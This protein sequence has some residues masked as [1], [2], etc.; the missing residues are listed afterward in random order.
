[1][2]TSAVVRIID[3]EKIREQKEQE[4]LDKL[5]SH[6]VEDP[7]W[8]WAPVY[9]QQHEH[10]MLPW[11]VAWLNQAIEKSKLGGL[12][13]E[14]ARQ[15]LWEE[16]AKCNAPTKPPIAPAGVQIVVRTN[17]TGLSGGSSSTRRRIGHEARLT[18]PFHRAPGSGSGT[19]G[20]VACQPVPE[21]VF[22]KGFQLG[23]PLR[24]FDYLRVTSTDLDVKPS[25]TYPIIYIRPKA[26]IIGSFAWTVYFLDK[27]V[28]VEI[29]P[30]GW[31][32]KF[33]SGTIRAQVARFTFIK[34]SGWWQTN[35][36][37]ERGSVY[38]T[39][40]QENGS[41]T[42]EVEDDLAF[43]IDQ[44]EV[45]VY[46]L[47]AVIMLEADGLMRLTY[48][49]DVLLEGSF[50][51]HNL[52]TSSPTGDAN[53]EVGSIHI[54][55][56]ENIRLFVDGGLYGNGTQSSP[57]RIYR[58]ERLILEDLRLYND[59][60]VT[61][62][63]RL[64]ESGENIQLEQY[65]MKKANDITQG[66]A[67]FNLD[68]VELSY[69]D[70]YRVY[71]Y[72]IHFQPRPYQPYD[73]KNGLFFKD[74]ALDAR[75]AYVNVYDELGDINKIRIKVKDEYCSGGDG[76]EGNPFITKSYLQKQVVFEISNENTVGGVVNVTYKTY[77]TN[78]TYEYH[79]ISVMAGETVEVQYPLSYWS[80]M[81]TSVEFTIACSENTR[82]FFNVP[83]ISH[84]KKYFLRRPL[85]TR[86]EFLNEIAV[87]FK[88]GR[89]KYSYQEMSS[90]PDT[91]PCEYVSVVRNSW[92][93]AYL[94]VN[95]INVEVLSYSF[96]AI[97]NGT[98]RF[99]PSSSSFS[100][101]ETL[102]SLLKYCPALS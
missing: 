68:D 13:Y 51:R 78:G 77:E 76:T 36:L 56:L 67:L 63:F 41:F 90:D 73:G 15:A 54:A 25:L 100:V 2:K 34:V 42:M 29:T 52:V 96:N 22:I 26:T 72:R 92:A 30:G 94:G 20:G 16:M 33:L 60:P 83:G 31:S 11:S 43:W 46:A 81:S 9:L 69:E 32:I 4:L 71:K 57:Y 10:E 59:N 79:T 65:E 49:Q 85:P 86:E 55:A 74:H 48:G 89:I 87:T 50:S 101:V 14:Q 91:I 21:V 37:I 99:Y 70:I 66:E 98:R 6:D 80:S 44:A 27:P 47:D 17:P 102:N 5:N 58:K 24:H 23:V 93:D 1:M 3:C 61:V 53:F 75:V 35:Y 8:K 7:C 45:G 19:G 95:D 84:V 82:C 12:T 88:R 40:I 62:L 38:N 39:E 64:D 18:V 28:E 97:Q